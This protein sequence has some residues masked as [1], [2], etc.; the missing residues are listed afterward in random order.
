[1]TPHKCPVCDGR[2]VVFKSD[3]AT[4]EVCPA[5]SGSCILWEPERIYIKPPYAP[6]LKEV[7][8]LHLHPITDGCCPVSHQSILDCI[9]TT[10]GESG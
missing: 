3:A 7:V 2:G 1:M 10:K 8:P 9:C 4:K 5:C 6:I